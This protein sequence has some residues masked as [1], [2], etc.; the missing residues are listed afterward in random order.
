M[1]SLPGCIRAG[2]SGLL[3]LS[4]SWPSC[5]YFE[6]GYFRTGVNE[7]TQEIVGRRYGAPHKIEILDTGESVWTYYDRGSATASYGGYAKRT[8]CRAYTLTFD[9]EG[10]LRDWKQQEC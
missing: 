6:T 4:I 7:A 10:I 3:L 5:S 9:K 1:G 8:F 2:L